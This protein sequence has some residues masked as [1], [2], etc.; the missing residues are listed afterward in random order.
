MPLA[1]LADDGDQHRLD[2]PAGGLPLGQLEGQLTRP[3]I[4][5]KGG[6]HEYA[7]RSLPQIEHHSARERD[8]CSIGI[9][10]GRALL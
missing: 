2:G 9:E 4:Y 1:R 7:V 8:I 5:Y 6:T 10:M 3:F